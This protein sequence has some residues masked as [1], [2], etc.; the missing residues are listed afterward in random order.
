MTDIA[1]QLRDTIRG[2]QAACAGLSKDQLI[3]HPEPGWSIAECIEHLNTGN[4]KML[5]T[6][7]AAVAGAPRSQGERKLRVLERVFLWMLEP[8]SRVKVKAPP[9]FQPETR[10]IDPDR[11]LA[12]F[13]TIVESAAALADRTSAL[14]IDQVKVSSPASDKLQYS[15][16]AGLHIIA[17][18]NRRHIWQ[19]GKVRSKLI[20]SGE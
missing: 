15:V 16:W 5:A 2:A 13:T 20:S 11:A 7:E 1:S 19:A 4:R 14:A 17:A 10:A 12:D 6:M 18:H 9:S 3:A 8:P